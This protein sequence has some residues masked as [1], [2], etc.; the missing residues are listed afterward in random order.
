MTT[1]LDIHNRKYLYDG[2]NNYY[3]KINSYTLKKISKKDFYKKS[4]Y[5]EKTINKLLYKSIYSGQVNDYILLRFPKWLPYID[6]NKKY[7]PT[8]YQLTNFIKFLWKN[9]IITLHWNQPKNKFGNIGSIDIKPKTFNNKNVINILLK[10]FG[11]KNIIIYD[12]IKNTK[13]KKYMQNIISKNKISIFIHSNFLHIQFSEKKL[14]WMHKKLNIIIPKKK[15]ASKGGIILS[16]DEI[17][18]CKIL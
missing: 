15:E 17:K 3:K 18:S 6:K 1:I 9:K 7:V 13:L 2:Y 14:K 5:N 4:K 12:C 10:F 11:E 16:N 8:D